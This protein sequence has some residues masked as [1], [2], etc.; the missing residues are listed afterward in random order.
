MRVEDRVL[1]S[2]RLNQAP[3]YF[4][5]ISLPAERGCVKGTPGKKTGQSAGD[6]HRGGQP[7]SSMK[8]QPRFVNTRNRPILS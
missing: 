8:T 2:A 6:P 4:D 3:R 5:K 7:A 1:L